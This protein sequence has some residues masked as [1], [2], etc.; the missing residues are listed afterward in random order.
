V[1]GAPESAT[2][3][4]ALS[5][6]AR[7]WPVFP[8]HTPT[9]GGSCDCRKDGCD[10][11]GKHPRTMN[12]LTSATTDP[13]AIRRWWKMWPSANV[14]ILTGA[15]SGL[16]V[17][18]VDGRNGGRETL[19]TLTLP[20]TLTVETGDGL[21]MYF[22]HPGGAVP[23]NSDILPG[24]DRKADGGY[25]VAPPSLHASGRL[26]RF[27][28]E[29]PADR[30]LAP[31]PAFAL[32]GKRPPSVTAGAP[33]ARIP[34]GKRNETL[35][36]LAG[37]MRKRG[38][39]EDAIEAALLAENAARCDPSLPDAEVARIAASVARYEPAEPLALGA[40]GPVVVTL[41]DVEREEVRWLWPG[42]I[43]KGRLTC[44]M[45][46]PGAGK[47]WITGAL[48]TA[49]S[50][51]ERLPGETERT[52]P[53]DVLFLCAE[54]GLADTVRPRLEDLGA[55]LTKIHVL[56][57][58]R[59]LDGKERHPSLVDNLGDLERVL[60]ER[61]CA[62]LVIDPINAYLG[63]Q[64]DT[65]RDAALRGA[66]APVAALCERLGVA[67]VFVLH[68]T[69]S[70]R[71]RAMY[72]G[73]GSIAYTAAAR[74]VLL[75]GQNP[76]NPEER[77]LVWVK[78]NLTAPPPSIGYEISEGRFYWRGESDLTAGQI[79]APDADTGKQS[80]IKEAEAFL[81]DTLAD[82][83]RSSRE[84]EREAEAFGISAMTLR[85]ARK[86]AGVRAVPVRLVGK[87]G[88]QSW[89]WTLS[90]KAATGLD[91]QDV[92]VEN[93]N[94]LLEFASESGPVAAEVEHLTPGDSCTICGADVAGY[95]PDGEPRCFAHFTTPTDGPLVRHAVG[96]GLTIIARH[97]AFAL[98]C[99]DDANAPADFREASC[100]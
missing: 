73:Q 6:A 20:E 82:G 94:T 17:I 56:T 90:D 41:A 76:E 1:S 51:G 59:G 22:K 7:G 38:M 70:G 53:A 37:T 61:P 81:L 5:Y 25:V 40:L 26:Y 72:R 3:Q 80:A 86:Q 85:R 83:P 89:T 30:P 69:K 24:I 65:H 27:A 62:L 98:C 52:E 42:R 13:E 99:D 21:H 50:R 2:G 87:E 15:G 14:G 35:A 49:V 74:V 91:V 34:Q 60:A 28:A 77:A 75:A 88:I 58:V 9:T 29:W 55:D 11:I 57:A 16:V 43:A 46:D 47:S 39:T 63:S 23:S 68:L 10:S 71:D 19:A 93:L 79:L 4:A 45:G 33:G 78:G 96:L 54:D 84:V 92:Q 18:D 8:L 31:L 36:S 97:P 44:L 32:N 100:V 48:A 12:G 64:L 95:T 66:L 67:C